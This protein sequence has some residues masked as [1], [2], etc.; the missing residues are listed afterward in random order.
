L[1]L[2]F[3]SLS[4]I[5]PF[6]WMLSTSL[7]DTAQ[8]YHVPPILVPW[9]L[10]FA[11]FPEAMTTQPFEVFI[12]NTLKYAVLSS[13]GA[14]LSASL[15]A[16]GFSRIRWV[17]R[18]IL[19]FVCLC[20]LMI[21]FQVRMVPLYIIFRDLHWLNGYKPLIIPSYFGEAY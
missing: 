21:P 6:L 3:L 19:F 4:F 18:D 14:V 2:A 12:L 20:T 10:R 17:G 9:P 8:T 7:K 1:L 15:V 16:Y 5:A 11:N 13:I